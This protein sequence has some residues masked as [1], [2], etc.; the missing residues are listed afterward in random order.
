MAGAEVQ[1]ILCKSLLNRVDVPNFPFRWTINR[2]RGC[3]H[4][5]TYCY[6]R[7][8]H[9]FLGLDS[10][11]EFEQRV[12]A[13]VNAPQVLRQELARPKWQGETIAIG[14]ASDPYEPAESQYKL[15]RRILEVLLEFQNP[16]SITTKGVL[17]RRDVDVLRELSQVADVQVVFR[18]GS[19][20]DQTWKLTEPGAP[21]PLARLEAMQYL[22]ENGVTAG[23]IL[24]PLLPGISDSSESIHA[25]VGAA[26][27]HRAQF[28]ASNVLFLKPGS[29]EW[30]M[31]MLREAYP[32][33]VPA[34]EK[35]Y[36]KTYA[37]REYAREVQQVVEEARRCWRLPAME[38]ARNLQGPRRRMQ[39]AF[40]F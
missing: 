22:V 27:D 13:K 20:D 4:A 10:G 17:V 25:V 15:T 8:T 29:K 32:R 1:E 28:L 36:R 12:F 19:I 16:V 23:V 21:R 14:T 26:A 5:C 7:P 6:A 40:S 18:V 11:R 2:Y 35:L 30:F 24:A 33:L 31:P 9:E 39:L 3:R 38:P 37:P 34:Y